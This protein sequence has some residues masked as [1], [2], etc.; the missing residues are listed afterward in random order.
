[1]WRT[2][3]MHL[4]DHL[5]PIYQLSNLGGISDHFEIKS[6]YINAEK[7]CTKIERISNY[8]EVISGYINSKMWC[9]LFVNFLQN[10]SA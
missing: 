4:I 10:K 7:W 3:L 8:L 5:N 2:M 6:R 1:M 9:I